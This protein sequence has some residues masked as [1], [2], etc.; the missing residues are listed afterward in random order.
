MGPSMARQ[1][2][3]C[4]DFILD[5]NPSENFAFFSARACQMSW[6]EGCFRNLRIVHGMLI[7]LNIAVAHPFPGDFIGN[8][9][10]QIHILEINPKRDKFFNMCGRCD[11]TLQRLDPCIIT[12]FLLH[13]SV[14]PFYK[15]KK[16]RRQVPRCLS[17]QPA[18]VTE[19]HRLIISDG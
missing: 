7:L 10:Q 1:V 15:R 5:E 14:F 19:C 12:E 4:G 3:C 16:V 2:V 11:L 6:F 8:L 18:I 13:C 9:W 17:I